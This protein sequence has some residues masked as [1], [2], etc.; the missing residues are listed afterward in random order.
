MRFWINKYRPLAAS[1]GGIRAADRAGEPLFVDASHRR[2][3]YLSEKLATISSICR[4]MQFAPRLRKGDAVVYL[5]TKLYAGDAQGSNRL[6]AVLELVEQFQS[7]EEAAAWLKRKG[8]PVPPNCLVE[9]CDGL[10]RDFCAP[11]S[12]DTRHDAEARY[13]SRVERY[14]V[15]F[16]C[17]PL[18]LDLKSPPIV[19]DAIMKRALGKVVPR[20]PITW[21]RR[22]VEALLEEVGVGADCLPVCEV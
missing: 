15:Y 10:H 3:P 7:H 19:T 13:R 2:E 5:T 18:W 6:T 11:C 12:T 9:G 16:I 1:K 21:K 14:P 22:E 8:L 17:C 4:G 20:T